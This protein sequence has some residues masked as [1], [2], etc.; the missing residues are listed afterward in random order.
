[1]RL[2]S[3][4]LLGLSLS[5]SPWVKAAEQKLASVEVTVDDKVTTNV[6]GVRTLYVIVYDNGSQM[7]RP[8]GAMKVDLKADAKGT[9]YKGDLTV[10][11]EGKA[12]NVKLMGATTLP[13]SIRLKARLDKDGSAGMDQPGDVVGKVDKVDVGGSAKITINS[14]IK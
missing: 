6:A 4:L 13:K 1:M 7:P 11:P 10:D 5:A 8:Y 9:V 12:G 3:C 2:F 14:V